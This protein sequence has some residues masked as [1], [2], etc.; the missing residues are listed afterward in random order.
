MSQPEN[1]EHYQLLKNEDGSF[2]ELG[3]GA[4][5][6]TYKAFDTN[7]RCTVTLKVISAAFLNDPTAEERFLREARGAAKL[8][9]RNVA[10]VFHLGRSGDS[11]F[12]S[13]EFIE[14]ETLDALVKREGALDLIIALDIAAQVSNALIAAA[15][16][17]LV[18]RDIKPSNL[19]LVRE[20][21]GEMIVKVIDFGLVKSALLGSTAGALTSTGFVGTPYFASPEQLDQ[22]NEDIRSDIYSLGVTLWFMLTG[23]PTFLGSVASVIAQHMEKLPS[24]ESL[25]VLPKEVVAVLKRML[26]KD[27][28]LRYQNPTELRADLKRCIEGLRNS[29]SS[30]RGLPLASM[31]ENFETI[32]LSSTDGLRSPPGPGALLGQR[33]RLIEDLNTTNPNHTF[34]AEDVTL[35]RRVRVKIVRGDATAFVRV[36]KD[37]ELL[38]HSGAPNFIEV[39]S[40]R[41]SGAVGFVVLE[42]LEGFSLLDL[43]RVRR[44]LTLRETLTILE[45]M[46]PAID[47]ARE[48]GLLLE[49]RLRDVLIHFPEGFGQSDPAVILRCPIAE[50][51]AFLLKLNPLGC[52]QE[53]ESSAGE[54]AERTMVAAPQRNP[55]AAIVQIGAIAHDLLGGKQGRLTPL[56]NLSE[57]GNA[58]LRRCLNQAETFPTAGDFVAE[59]R[60]SA[61]VEAPQPPAKPPAQTIF[62]GVSPAQAAQAAK[63]AGAPPQPQSPPPAPGPS[64]PTVPML[65]MIA[66]LVGILALI[67]VGAIW[68]YSGGGGG[69]SAPVNGSVSASAAT[70]VSSARA[71]VHRPP[72]RQGVAW[73][74]SLDMDFVPLGEI[75][76]GAF[77]TRVSDFKAFVD[78]E[79]YEAIGGML[80]HQK[81]GFKDHGNNSWDQPGFHQNPDEPVVGVSY[82]DAKHF[83]DWLTAKERREGSLRADQGY[84]LP[85]DEEWSEAVGLLAETGA[86]PEDRSG[87][88]KGVYPW[89]N[90]WPPP[91]DTRNYAG[92]ESKAGNPRDWQVV[93]NFSDKFQ[94][95][96]PVMK[97]APNRLGIYD[98]GGNAWEWCRDEFNN[99]SFKWHALRGGSWATSTQEQMLSSFRLNLDPSFRQDDVGFRCVIASDGVDR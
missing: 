84:R 13:M 87:R 7:L 22:Q 17:N 62:A 72:P 25:A 9:H 23:R 51:P 19:M 44:E 71:V 30:A 8:R 49:L 32:A 12:Y 59:L 61:G 5:G 36:Q 18:H 79:S 92:A 28:S 20:D 31:E 39:L 94:R 90:T 78:S 86:T 47:K 54:E 73:K 35:K 46:A 37:V 66:G 1:F 76:F 57:A 52:I 14:G 67:A 91:P 97:F 82:N 6:I 45:Q 81:D 4:M 77:K 29:Q 11:Y 16:Q 43:L 68:M 83:C 69:D 34:H 56:S 99:S 41:R 60:R 63:N 40:A 96:S 58:A 15:K 10:S 80:T 38:K 33:Y 50:W 2:M 75:H 89:G 26:E 53:V 85:R 21:D 55:G 48:F 70:P 95:T 98:L 93:P 24:F 65:P 74:N 64:K 27:L 3:R 42:W 88:I